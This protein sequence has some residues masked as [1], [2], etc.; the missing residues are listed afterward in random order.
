MID[1]AGES[2]KTLKVFNMYHPSE[3]VSIEEWTAVLMDRAK[4]I[5]AVYMSIT[6]VDF[7]YLNKVYD[8]IERSATVRILALQCEDEQDEVCGDVDDNVIEQWAVLVP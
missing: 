4:G 8:A 5:T 7:W 6:V 3:I 2:L 1:A